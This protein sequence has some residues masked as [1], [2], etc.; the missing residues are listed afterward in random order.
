MGLLGRL[1]ERGIDVSDESRVGWELEKERLAHTLEQK[2]VSGLGGSRI[3]SIAD[4]FG[5]LWELRRAS[6]EDIESISGINRQ[7]A[8]KVHEAVR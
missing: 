1:R 3:R 2:K 5:S 4:R 6:V 7:L 8:E